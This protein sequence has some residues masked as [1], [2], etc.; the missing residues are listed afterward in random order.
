M[1]LKENKIISSKSSMEK[2]DENKKGVA[3]LAF[4]SVQKLYE[5]DISWSTSASKIRRQLYTKPFMASYA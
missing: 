3:H 1:E 2:L 5:M 4:S